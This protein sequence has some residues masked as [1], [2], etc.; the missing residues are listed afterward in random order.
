MI[1][2]GV[3]LLISSWAVGAVGPGPPIDLRSPFSEFPNRLEIWR[4]EDQRF[5]Q[6]I[7]DR[8][9]TTDYLSKLYTDGAGNLVH[10]YVGYY[11]S[12]RHGEMIH[13]PKSCLP[14]NGWYI[15]KRG[16]AMVKAAPYEGFTVNRYIVENGIDRQVVLYW[17]QQSGGRL[18]RNE[19]LG[20]V[21]L[22]I[23]SLFKKRSDAA[24]IRISVPFEEDEAKATRRGLDFLKVGYPELMRF[25][26]H[27]IASSA[28]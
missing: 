27:D 21:H 10:L 7:E 3:M 8:L 4:G 19:Y 20:R 18:V 25:L 12:Q 6:K 9:G 5:D 1:V 26:P 15:A 16:N 13:S 2:V 17:Y 28:S 22:V 23:D 24:L 14:G 11:S